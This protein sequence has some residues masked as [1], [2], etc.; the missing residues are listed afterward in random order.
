VNSCAAN[1]SDNACETRDLGHTIDHEEESREMM[2]M[3]PPAARRGRILVV[4]DDELMLRSVKRNLKEHDVVV[5]LA[6]E[7]ALA[8]CVGGETFDLILCD[9]MMPGMS[10]M[11]LHRELSRIAPEQASKMIFLSGG[12][13]TAQARQFFSQVPNERIEK[14]FDPISLRAIVQRHLPLA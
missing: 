8:L 10:G 4:D 9:M 11:D 12:V 2:G 5:V 14:P 1:H 3:V 7:A 13:A 6:A